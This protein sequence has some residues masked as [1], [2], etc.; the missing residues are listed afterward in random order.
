MVPALD[1]E[2]RDVGDG[3]EVGVYCRQRRHVVSLKL[4][5]QDTIADDRQLAQVV[6]GEGG[7]V[8]VRK[9][10]VPRR[11]AKL[12]CEMKRLFTACAHQHAADRWSFFQM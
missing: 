3:E 6:E 7:A 8:C 1:G 2:G 9:N 12:D 4:L 5:F 11:Q 10:D